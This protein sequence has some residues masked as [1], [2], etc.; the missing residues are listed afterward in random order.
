MHLK[1][2]RQGG[3]LYALYN[4]VAILE[5]LVVSKHGVLLKKKR[6]KGG[7]YAYEN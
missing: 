3:S 6:N 5:D 2:N 4:Y 7:R 1:N